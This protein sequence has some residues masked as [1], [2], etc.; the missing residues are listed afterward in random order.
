MKRYCIVFFTVFAFL[1]ASLLATAADVKKFPTSV[2]PLAPKVFVK[3]PVFSATEVSNWKTMLQP[4]EVTITSINSTG[5][6]GYIVGGLVGHKNGLYRYVWKLKKDLFVEWV[7]PIMEQDL[8]PNFWAFEL[9]KGSFV[10]FFFRGTPK[11]GT[12]EKASPL[13]G[14]PK[15]ILTQFDPSGKLKDE[16]AFVNLNPVLSAISTLDGEI[17]FTDKY[18]KPSD[19][20]KP[21]DQL[22]FDEV[23]GRLVGPDSSMVNMFGNDLL[24]WEYGRYPQYAPEFVEHPLVRAAGSGYFMVGDGGKIIKV[25][26]EFKTSWAQTLPLPIPGDV[27]AI[28]TKDGGFAVIGHHPKENTTALL[29][30]VDTQGN[31]LWAKSYSCADHPCSFAQSPVKPAIVELQH[32][33]FAFAYYLPAS[34]STPKRIKVIRIAPSGGFLWERSIEVGKELEVVLEGG[35]FLDEYQDTPGTIIVMANVD[36]PGSSNSGIWSWKLEIPHGAK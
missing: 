22:A 19:P 36:Q 30:R 4:G 6:G 16:T 10:S 29:V 5:D 32:G 23:Y 24:L 8:P 25:T 21:P 34:G 2:R 13:E 33:G 3:Q 14:C 20:K 26:K 15:V 27:S 12:C 35:I 11:G 9:N 31:Q 17:F 1:L 18:A 7:T 28:S